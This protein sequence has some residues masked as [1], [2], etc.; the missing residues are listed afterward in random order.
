VQNSVGSRTAL[1]ARMGLA[2]AAIATVVMPFL[3]G[4]PWY[5]LRFIQRTVSSF[6][7]RRTTRFVTVFTT[8]R[9]ARDSV[10]LGSQ[11]QRDGGTHL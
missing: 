9:R 6:P 11:A 4:A 10:I 3:A 2:D 8:T 1:S 5:R 7:K